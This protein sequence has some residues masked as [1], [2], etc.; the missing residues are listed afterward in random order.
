MSKHIQPISHYLPHER[1]KTFLTKK[2]QK[3]STFPTR[4]LEWDA[5]QPKSLLGSVKNRYFRPWF[6]I[7]GVWITP[8]PF[9][10][11][12]VDSILAICYWKYWPYL[13]FSWI[14]FKLPGT[15]I[16]FVLECCLVAL[17]CKIILQLHSLWGLL[18]VYVLHMQY[19]GWL[20]ESL[21][22]AWD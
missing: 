4:T 12:W 16:L 8:D 20:H 5:S 21:R 2:V 11:S 22:C 3:F 19:W 18:H 1:M 15:C 6:G 10:P 9:Y 17:M 7:G 13:L 14:T